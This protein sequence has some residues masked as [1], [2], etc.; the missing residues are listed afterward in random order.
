MAK[1]KSGEQTE[2]P[3]PKRLKD[4]RKEGDVSKSREL[5]STV[6]LL[7]WLA[8]AWLAT[9]LVVHELMELFQH[10]FETVGRVGPDGLQPISALCLQAFK[11]LL[12]VSLPLLIAAALIGTLSEFLQVGGVFAPKRAVPK[13][14]R[15]NPAEGIKRMF[16][17]QNLIEVAKSV[18]KT[19]ALVMIF[20]LVLRRLLPEVL[21][22]PFGSPRDL[23]IAHWH[24][25]MWLGIWTISVFFMLAALDAGYQR[26]AFV[27]K[28]RM[29]RREIRQELRDSEGDPFVK[30]RRRQLHLEWAQENMRQAVR[31]SS[32]VVVNPEHI[33]V[34]IW[35]EPGTTELP[36]VCAKGEDYEA[37][38]IR[39]T[40]EQAGVPIMR[41]VQLARG[42]H[43][44]VGLDEYNSAE[45]FRAVAE[46]LRWAESI[47]RHG[48]GSQ[49]IFK[50]LQ[51]PAVLEQPAG[52]DLHVS[53]ERQQHD[54]GGDPGF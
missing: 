46:L 8:M 12:L 45:F 36:M 43:E 11:T 41:N 51:Q 7:G 33:A 5:T 26:Y 29:S 13:L 39:E 21:R 6:T 9:P 34:A 17:Q 30:A 42:L 4:A 10:S 49:H 24:V 32:A 31:K 16:S 18:F 47:P 37:Q 15:L 35:Y 2:K 53:A 48:P 3:T 44:K 1:P 54:K 19:A 22:L 40:A 27:K 25:L 28:M 23:G 52:D 50:N 20:W 14:E 38:L